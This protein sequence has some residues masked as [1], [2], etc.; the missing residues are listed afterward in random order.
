MGFKK[1]IKEANTLSWEVYKKDV[2][3]ILGL[4][5]PE[6]QKKLKQKHIDYMRYKVMLHILCSWT[7]KLKQAYNTDGEEAAKA[8]SDK[9]KP[10]IKHLRF[11]EDLG[12]Y[13]IVDGNPPSD[14]ERPEWEKGLRL[15]LDVYQLDSS[16]WEECRPGGAIAEMVHERDIHG[17]SEWENYIHNQGNLIVNPY[18]I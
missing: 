12:E 14:S 9:H 4:Y 16:V 18:E 1:D 13:R 15:E 7:E 6:T 3:P 17:E 5:G 2:E 10:I 8:Y 11:S